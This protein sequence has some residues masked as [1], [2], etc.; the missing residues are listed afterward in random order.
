[1]TQR[2][3]RAPNGRTD[4]VQHVPSMVHSILVEHDIAEALQAQEQLRF[5][6]FQKVAVVSTY[7]FYFSIEALY[8][9]T[10]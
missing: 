4:K 7:A 8:F 9:D 2:S 6:L 3:A 5:G 10:F 1:M